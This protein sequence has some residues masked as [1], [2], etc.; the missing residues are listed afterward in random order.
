MH[1]ATV[2]WDEGFDGWTVDLETDG[3]ATVGHSTAVIDNSG[4][5]F[6]GD[7]AVAVLSFTGRVPN[8]PYPYT[9]PAS[10]EGP[11]ITSDVFTGHAGDIIRFVYQLSS[12][13]NSG[14]S[15]LGTVTGKIIDVS[16]GEVVQT[17]YNEADLGS[18]TRSATVNMA[19]WSLTVNS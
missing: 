6:E 13:I 10:A 8:Q 15:D 3:L 17:I 11:S 4:N 7:S 5:I 12:G 16:T 19:S 1:S 14:S 9:V 2:A 18:S